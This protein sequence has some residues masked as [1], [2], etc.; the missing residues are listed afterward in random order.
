MS[1]HCIG[2]FYFM[3][4]SIF[5]KGD[6]REIRLANGQMITGYH[7]RMERRWERITIIIGSDVYVAWYSRSTGF[8]DTDLDTCTI[9]T[10]DPGFKGSQL[11]VRK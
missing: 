4:N 9:L 10:Q 2:H 3:T 5:N 8:I 11:I 6:H 7:S 1:Y